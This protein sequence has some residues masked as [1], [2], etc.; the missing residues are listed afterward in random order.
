MGRNEDDV[1]VK[2]RAIGEIVNIH[3]PTTHY[4]ML[5]PT[6]ITRIARTTHWCTTQR[7]FN[8]LATFDYSRYPI[9]RSRTSINR[10]ISP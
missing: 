6:R 2:T 7:E 3:M 5:C 8:Y 10:I 9:E 1:H 4:D